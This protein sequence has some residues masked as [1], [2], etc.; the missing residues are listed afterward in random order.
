MIPI[1]GIRL[2]REMIQVR[3]DYSPELSGD[4]QPEYK[5]LSRDRINMTC[6]GMHHH[7]F[8]TW[9]SCCLE[10]N[11]L[12][13]EKIPVRPH[14]A[15]PEEP[16]ILAPK[17][18]TEI[19]LS[20]VCIVSIYP[21]HSNIKILACL[22]E[23]FSRTD[24]MFRH[25]VSSNAMLSFVVESR[26][27]DR[28]I[29]FIQNTFLLPDSHTPFKQDLDISQVLKKYPETQASYVE[30][31]IKTYGICVV[32]DLSLFR[33]S[34]APEDLSAWGS[35]LCSMDKTDTRFFFSSGLGPACKEAQDPDFCYDLALVT[36]PL[37]PADRRCLTK[38]LPGF[39]AR[40]SIVL[41]T[42]DLISFHGPH[43]GDRYRILDTA[44]SCMAR[45]GL[46]ILYVGCTGASIS[47]VVPSGRGQLAR[48]ALEMGFE[49]P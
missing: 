9:F 25:M 21:H 36:A 23:I 3:Q 15:G 18:K 24:I 40:S 30:E 1:N 33:L 45:A 7:S 38:K 35:F 29:S 5:R 44:L 46:P 22:L 28:V 32:P 14:M 48:E 2:S 31:R 37:A 39:H 41:D 12:N 6:V 10:K 17:D 42:G 16:G 19:I 26:F 20:D 4:F 11:H 34:M 8:R 27:Q 43:F 47:L 13:K 49:A